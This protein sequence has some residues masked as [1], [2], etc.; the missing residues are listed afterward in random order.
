MGT[1]GGEKGMRGDKG[2]VDGI[3]L[4]LDYICLSVLLFAPIVTHPLPYVNGEKSLR[5]IQEPPRKRS[6]NKGYG[7]K[8]QTD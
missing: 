8:D 1:L 4:A 7:A 6:R 3:D 5:T 2:G